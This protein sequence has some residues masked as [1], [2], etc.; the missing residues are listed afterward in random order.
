MSKDHRPKTQEKSCHD[1]EVYL[2]SLLSKT[3][4]ILLSL[5][6]KETKTQTMAKTS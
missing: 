4:L 6:K 1:L 5:L 3:S 2:L